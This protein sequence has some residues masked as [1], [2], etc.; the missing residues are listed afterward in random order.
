MDVGRQ[1]FG[2]GPLVRGSVFGADPALRRV[3]IAPLSAPDLLGSAC[4]VVLSI[5]RIGMIAAACGDAAV[6]QIRDEIRRRGV[7]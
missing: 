6:R 2:G 4:C 3:G 5:D 1:G 7:R